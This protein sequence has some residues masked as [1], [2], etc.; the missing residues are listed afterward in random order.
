MSSG[1]LGGA[2]EVEFWRAEAKRLAV[3]NVV[4]QTRVDDLE[5]R[6]V[7]EFDLYR[8]PARRRWL[9]SQPVGLPADTLAWLVFAVPRDGHRR[10]R[11]RDPARVAIH[12]HPDRITCEITSGRRLPVLD[13]DALRAGLPS[14]DQGRAGRS[15]LLGDTGGCAADVPV[16]DLRAVD[17]RWR[18]ATT[19]TTA[20]AC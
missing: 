17:R 10:R 16:P 1:D 18:Y 19:T 6:S 11:L 5:S 2:G 3:E 4:L 12:R 7:A 15:P 13:T 8:L 9:R 20:T 14:L